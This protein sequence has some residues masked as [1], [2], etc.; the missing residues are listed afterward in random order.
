[1]PKT[2]DYFHGKTIVITGAGSGIGRATA[3][4]FAREGANVV[5]SDI[6]EDGVK[7][8][9]EQLNALGAQALALTIDV[10]KRAAVN[11]MIELA[12]NDFGQVHSL[13]NSA[14]AALR[15]SKFLDIDDDLLRAHARSQFEGHLLRHA[16]GAAAYAEKQIRR[17]RQCGK[18]GAS[19]RRARLLDPLCRRQRRGGDHDHGRCARIR[20]RGHPRAVDFAGADQDA[21]CGGGRFLA[22]LV[23]KFL[24]DVPMGRFGEPEEIGELVLFMC[25]VPPP[26]WTPRRLM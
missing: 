19:A 16:G 23:Q 9:V 17:H 24:D 25:S 26:S 18:H 6:N 20:Q 10:T 13:F 21:V 8:T 1:M 15:R 22:E 2:P 12:I 14:G 11:D 4:I 7:E 3:K 5:C